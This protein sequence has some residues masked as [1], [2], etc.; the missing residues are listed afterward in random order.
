MARRG[1]KGTAKQTTLEADIL[2]GATS[3]A[4]IDAGGWPDGAT[5][6]VVTFERGGA[7]EEKKLCTRTVGSNTVQIVSQW[8]NTTAVAHLAGTIVEHTHSATDADEAN[9]LVNK[10][11]AKGDTLVAT[12]ADTWARKAV[13]AD[14]TILMA[15][16][17]QAD[18]LKWAAP[19]A[20]GASAPGDTAAAGT[21]D[22]FT[23][24]DHR[25]SREGFAGTPDLADVDAAAEAAGVAGTVAR[26]DHKHAAVVA[27]PG[28]SAP[29]DTAAAGAATSLS[30]SD[31][32]HGRE[33]LR[34]YQLPH[35]WAIPGEVRVPSGDVDFIVPFFIPVPA[36]QVV[37]LVRAAHIINSGT[38]AT[39][40][41]QKDGVDI[42]GWTGIVVGTTG[43]ITDGTDTTFIDGNRLA[44]V[45]TAVVGTPR[46]MSFTVFIEYEDT[47]A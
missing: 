45:V 30:R 34:T 32:K 6:F 23:R 27:A 25:H 18:G 15:D 41:L 7:S 36:G 12:A 47:S 22:S 35:T 8:D 3:F 26:G 39:V 31:H 4:A 13:G 10:A 21:G 14:D 24:G 11:D 2:S 28:S 37:R 9:D 43:T 19:A 5:P 1:Y 40:K 17:A 42:T 38:S 20:P 44:L 33:S 16:A 29:G 46:N